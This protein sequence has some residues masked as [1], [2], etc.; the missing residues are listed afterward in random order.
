MRRRSKVRQSGTPASLG[1]IS[2]SQTQL[3]QRGSS[4]RPQFR[5]EVVE[6][7]ASALADL[8]SM[9][10]VLPLPVPLPVG[11]KAAQYRFATQR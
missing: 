9:P 3:A 10:G 11:G 4:T 6:A 5:R 2:A 7:P 1:V 8:E